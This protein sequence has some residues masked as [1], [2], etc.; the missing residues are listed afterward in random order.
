MEDKTIG[1]VI[2]KE[3]EYV[4]NQGCKDTAEKCKQDLSELLSNHFGLGFYRWH[5]RDVI[6]DYFEEQY[7]IK[8]D[9]VKRILGSELAKEIDI[10][11]KE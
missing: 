9:A 5:C 10:E 11:V 6:D 7:G 2:A 1:G 8:E 4:Y 3:F